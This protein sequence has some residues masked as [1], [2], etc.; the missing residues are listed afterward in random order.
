MTTLSKTRVP[1]TRENTSGVWGSEDVPLPFFI[2]SGLEIREVSSNVRR[3]RSRKLN[4]K[5]AGPGPSPLRRKPYTSKV[6]HWFSSGEPPRS[7]GGCI[8]LSLEEKLLAHEAAQRRKSYRSKRLVAIRVGDYLESYLD[9]D[10][11]AVVTGPTGGMGYHA[12]FVSRSSARAEAYRLDKEA[13]SIDLRKAVLTR[14]SLR[15]H[16]CTA[17]VDGDFGVNQV[18]SRVERRRRKF[19]ENFKSDWKMYDTAVVMVAGLA[20]FVLIRTIKR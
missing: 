11:I 9:S 13:E 14:E 4:P 8:S 12:R 18:T 19:F 2:L 5:N 16:L 20:L 17:S 3:K 10:D 7:V 1:R 15:L 6:H